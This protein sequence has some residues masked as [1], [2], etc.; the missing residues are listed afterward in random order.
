MMCG[1][2]QCPWHGSQFDVTTGAVR[3]GP[4][5]APVATYRVETRNGELRLVL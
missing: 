5:Q 4:A 3:A 1:V 2:V